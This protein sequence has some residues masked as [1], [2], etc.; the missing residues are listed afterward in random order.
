MS[1]KSVVA[2]NDIFVYLNMW[3]LIDAIIC[4][5]LLLGTSWQESNKVEYE[6]TVSAIENTFIQSVWMIQLS[7]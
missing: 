4:A 7:I 6:I 3:D 2:Q 5:T 1:Y